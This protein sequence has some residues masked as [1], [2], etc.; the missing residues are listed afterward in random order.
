MDVVIQTCQTAALKHSPWS[1]VV[2]FQTLISCWLL[3]NDGIEVS[4]N[5]PHFGGTWILSFK[6][7]T[8]KNLTFGMK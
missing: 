6:T 4:R 5:V 8:N 3:L 1:F 7:K 2:S